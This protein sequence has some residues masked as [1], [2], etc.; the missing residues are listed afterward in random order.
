M[1]STD[2]TSSA[3]RFTP[4]SRKAKTVTTG[5]MALA[6]LA[7]ALG[8]PAFS[9]QKG[10][11]AASD[12]RIIHVLNRLGFGARPDDVAKVRQ[13]G[14]DAY[15]EQQLHP[16]QIDD[17]AVEQKLKTFP[18]LQLSD[19]EIEA[20]YKDFVTA[21][22]AQAKMRR[23]LQKMAS[24]K[25]M[26]GQAGDTMTQTAGTGATQGTGTIPPQA[27]QATP[28]ANKAKRDAVQEMIQGD[29]MLAKQFA[30]NRQALA[31]SAQPIGLLHQEFTAAKLIRA[32]ES[33]RQLQE[34]LV[35]F[36]SN[37]FNIDIRK[38][39]CGV[40]KVLDDRDVIRPHIFGKFRGTCSRPA[41]RA[42]RCSS[43]WITSSR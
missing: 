29:P 26:T 21:D 17:S 43:T 8:S 3:K 11:P 35:D 14:L 4:V 22:Q 19:R 9:A 25:T 40:L 18:E 2:K 38:A 12:D 1:M 37:H 28:A 32:T 34:V 23:D 16:E 6:A 33:Q 24:E 42:R 27:N 36:W 31:E 15:I 10:K 30:D 13:I 41:P 20:K 5:L 39:P 7:C